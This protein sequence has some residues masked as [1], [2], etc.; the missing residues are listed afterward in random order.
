MLLHNKKPSATT[1]RVQSGY[2]SRVTGKTNSR[3]QQVDLEPLD[4]VDVRTTLL[5]AHPLRLWLQLREHFR[6]TPSGTAQRA[7]D[8]CQ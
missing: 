3:G 2:P 7:L 8:A 6:G 5:N 4:E 1:G